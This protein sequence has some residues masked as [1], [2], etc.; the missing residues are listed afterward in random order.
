MSKRAKPDADRFLTKVQLRDRL[1]LPSTRALEDMVKARKI[2][3][4]RFGH[5][6]VRFDWPKVEAALERLEETEIGRKAA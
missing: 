2:P 1:N 6:T 3:V 4:L 5:R